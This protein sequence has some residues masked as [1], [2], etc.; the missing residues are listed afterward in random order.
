[1]LHT[2]RN[3]TD[4]QQLKQRAKE[5]ELELEG[6]L[7]QKFSHLIA[8]PAEKRQMQQQIKALLVVGDEQKMEDVKERSARRAALMKEYKK[9][10]KIWKKHK[11]I[12]MPFQQTLKGLKSLVREILLGQVRM[13]EI[14]QHILDLHF[15]KKHQKRIDRLVLSDEQLARRQEMYDNIVA[16]KEE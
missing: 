12:V 13:Q 14:R 8:E 1:M 6:E 3:I 2:L 4:P 16:P 11:M 7:I 5:I 9:M 15:K 10:S